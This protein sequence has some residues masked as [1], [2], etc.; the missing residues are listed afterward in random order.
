MADV[1]EDLLLSPN[2]TSCSSAAAQPRSLPSAGVFQLTLE[3]ANNPAASGARNN[4]ESPFRPESKF[5]SANTPSASG[6]TVCLRD[7]EVTKGPGS[8]LWGLEYTQDWRSK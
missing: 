1:Y 3:K 5:P 7:L 8:T 2:V 6:R 4:P